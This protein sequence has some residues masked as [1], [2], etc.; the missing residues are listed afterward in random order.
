MTS[1]VNHNKKKESK[2]EEKEKKKKEKE[3]YW[4]SDHRMFKIKYLEVSLVFFS[5]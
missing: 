2:R 3:K 5:F 1:V 4:E